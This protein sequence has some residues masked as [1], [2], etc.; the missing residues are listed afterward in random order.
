V[1]GYN[2]AQIGAVM[3]WTALPQLLTIP[4]V[5]ML[6]KR[7][8]ARLL[9]G[10]GFALF[11]ASNLMMSE[12]S[13]DVAAAQLLS[14]NVVRAVG[15]GLL[16]TPLSMLAIAG[17]G[18]ADAPSASALLAITRTLAGALGIAT[19]KTFLGRSEQLYIS[20]LGEAVSLL[21]D[22]TQA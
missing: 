9:A 7:V 3:A 20:R 2:S 21:D 13:R 8:D 12:L 11:A 6:M 19:L 16:V 14:P 10:L 17:I 15:E 5:P 18:V 22:D 1:Q 4:L